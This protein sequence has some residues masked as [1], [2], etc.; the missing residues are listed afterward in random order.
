MKGRTYITKTGRLV[1]IRRAIAKD[2]WIA[3]YLDRDQHKSGRVRCTQVP[4][5][6]EMIDAQ[7]N[8][9][10]HAWGHGGENA[11]MPGVEK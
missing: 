4:V 6:A 10:A 7:A 11:G 9:E 8:L 2:L 3:V 1:G 5:A